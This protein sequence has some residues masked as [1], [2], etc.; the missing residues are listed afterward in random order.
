MI[1]NYLT[2][3]NLIIIWINMLG[4]STDVELEDF[5][6]DKDWEPERKKN[7]VMMAIKTNNR[8]DS[9][10]EWNFDCE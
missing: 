2:L 5:L 9:L 6:N 4:M 7:K 1:F 8:K 3:K 10:H